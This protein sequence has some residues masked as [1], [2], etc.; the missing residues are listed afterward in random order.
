MRGC[1][2]TNG[3]AFATSWLTVSMLARALQASVLK[4]W[5]GQ[6]VNKA[7]AIEV[8]GA[9]AKANSEAQ[10]GQ[11]TGRHPTLLGTQSLHETHRGW[12]NAAP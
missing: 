12:S 1:L 6:E 2:S 10:L 7:A 5:Q 9:L 3:W 8:G 11:F 4:L